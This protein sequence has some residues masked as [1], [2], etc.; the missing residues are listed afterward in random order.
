MAAALVGETFVRRAQWATPRDASPDSRGVRAFYAELL[1]GALRDAGVLRN[2]APL[3]ARRQALA[4]AWLTGTLDDQVAL[5]IGFLCDALRLDAGALAAAVRA[6]A[7][8]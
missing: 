2:L 8:P 3:Q 6:R 7:T 1:R 5:P 4:V